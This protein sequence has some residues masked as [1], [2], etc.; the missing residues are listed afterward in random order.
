MRAT[1]LEREREQAAALHAAHPQY[2]RPRL[3]GL[4]IAWLRHAHVAALARRQPMHEHTAR[5]GRLAAHS[6]EVC[7]FDATLR[8]LRGDRRIA[9]LLQRE[10][11]RAGGLTIEALMTSQ[12]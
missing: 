5:R 7:L 1:G 9:G 8:E 10:Q 4:R 3:F 12:I 2:A 11:E 6:R